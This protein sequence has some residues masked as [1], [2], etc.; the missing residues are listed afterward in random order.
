MTAANPAE[1]ALPFLGGLAFGA[2]LRKGYPAGTGAGLTVAGV[3]TLG[4]VLLACWP[5]R[6]RAERRTEAGWSWW[7]TTQSGPAQGESFWRPSP[8]RR[9]LTRACLFLA[10]WLAG[11]GRMWMAV[12]PPLLPLGEYTRLFPA[13]PGRREVMVRGTAVTEAEPTAGGWQVFVRPDGEA[14]RNGLIR[15]T[16]GSG[17]AKV[18]GSPAY[19]VRRG[20]RL[21]VPVK[22]YRPVPANPGETPFAG[23]CPY[24]RLAALAWVPE[25]RLQAGDGAFSGRPGG[26]ALQQLRQRVV[27]V[28]ERGASLRGRGILRALLLGDRSELTDEVAEDFARAGAMHLLVVSGL[29]LS[30]VAGFLGELGERLKLGRKGRAALSAAGSLAY[31]ALTGWHSPVTRAA[32][33]AL[34][35]Q[36]A[37]WCGRRRHTVRALWA[38]ILLM[39]LHRPLLFFDAGFRL[40]AAA[41]WGVAALGPLL[42]A[43][44]SARDAIGRG[45]CFALGAQ[46]ATFPLVLHYFDRLPLAALAV[47]PLLVEAGAA[48]VEVGCVGTALGLALPFLAAPLAAGLGVAAE[49][50]WLMARVTG[51]VPGA[52]LNL[53]GPPEWLATLYYAALAVGWLAWRTADQPVP[54]GMPLNRVVPVAAGAVWLLAASGLSPWLQC[55]FLAVGEGDALHL[56]LPGGVFGADLVVDTG[57]SATRLL[58]YLRHSAVQSLAAV[59]LT[60]SH[61]DHAGG[62][63]GLH[64][65]LP[66]RRVLGSGAGGTRMESAAGV[67][68]LITPELEEGDRNEASRR[69]VVRYGRFCLLVT[70]DAPLTGTDPVLDYLPR[71]DTPAGKR[72]FLVVKIP[73][74]GARGAITPDF[75]AAYRPDLAVLSV[76]PNP[77]GHPDPALLGLLRRERIPVWRTD[78]A[79]AI[80]VSSDGKRVRL[81]SF[82]PSRGELLQI[83][84]HVGQF[85]VGM[86]GGIEATGH[87]L[88]HV[89][90]EQV[91]LARG[92]DQAPRLRTE[93]VGQVPGAGRWGRD[94]R[95]GA[96]GRLRLLT[97]GGAVVSAGGGGAGEKPPDAGKRSLFG[98]TRGR[99]GLR[100]SGCRGGGQSGRLPGADR[101]EGVRDQG[102][103]VDHRRHPDRK[104]R[105]AERFRRDPHPPVANARAG[106]DP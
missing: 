95:A 25:D 104:N 14:G 103:S 30:V 42:Q 56:R 1:L 63:E 71:R 80:R 62:W 38:S 50:L 83:P 29:H 53:P 97:V 12:G 7:H 98:L 102:D 105:H 4:S 88:G 92:D 43:R 84:H 45:W 100:S 5:L 72:L 23:V 15:L 101:I 39:L 37:E 93:E 57:P 33:M 21:V 10:L 99:F 27:K 17:P 11:A 36:G 28:F 75:L 66:V 86:K 76:G 20:T 13:V 6:G 19:R 70:G 41:T 52:T 81:R 64:R 59:V 55:T 48:L 89:V 31:A 74:H 87:D 32:L 79:G 54:L 77:Y 90:D 2:A 40:T 49:L 26:A 46:V 22:L 24:G 35:A 58:A 47:S 85:D 73:H 78:Q 16:V 51:R 67:V 3:L 9:R 106:V 60:H 44:L 65:S 69:I 68:V 96:G 94:A 34:A 61:R 91:D 18:G 82:G 8:G